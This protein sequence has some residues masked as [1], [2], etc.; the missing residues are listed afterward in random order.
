MSSK[1][2][3][4]K[5]PKM[6][7]LNFIIILFIA[8]FITTVSAKKRE[9]RTLNSLLRYFG[10]RVIPLS[11]TENISEKH[12]IPSEKNLN[13]RFLRLRT[14]LPS[15]V[16]VEWTT[17]KIAK[18]NEHV[19]SEKIRMIESTTTARQTTTKPFESTTTQ[20]IK[21][22]EPATESTTEFLI[23]L[24]DVD[25]ISSVENAT[26]IDSMMNTDKANSSEV[27][28]A[29][30]MTNSNFELIKSNDIYLGSTYINDYNYNPYQYIM[31]RFENIQEISGNQIFAQPNEIN[32]FDNY[33]A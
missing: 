32:N 26:N 27:N 14:I 9:K 22:T 30:I 1:K 3:I 10:Y 29:S 13:P 28:N 2:V 4:E 6:K 31:P 24:P 23:R 25:E 19:K 15:R 17:A 8:I 5:N 7:I 16:E 20:E 12:E 33:F 21:V 11:E 18:M